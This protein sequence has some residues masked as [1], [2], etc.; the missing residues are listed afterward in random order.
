MDKP[1]GKKLSMQLQ[2]KAAEGEN[3]DG[4]KPLPEDAPAEK[5]VK[6]RKGIADYKDRKE[7]ED[8]S[9]DESSEKPVII[10][11]VKTK[12]IL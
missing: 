4:K 11:R 6:I 7:A 12:K 3:G 10:C 2:I 5:V 8:D 9:A 1:K